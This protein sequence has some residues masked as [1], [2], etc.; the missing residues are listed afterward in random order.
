MSD[1]LPSGSATTQPAAARKSNFWSALS[2]ALVCATAAYIA[3]QIL[4]R[5][6]THAARRMW[7]PTVV[8]PD[9]AETELPAATRRLEFWTPSARTKDHVARE[10]SGIRERD[11]W[12]VLPNDEP[13][14]QFGILLRTNSNVLG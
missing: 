2:I 4:H 1:P 8:R 5:K 10:G 11:K 14:Q 12:E 9:G 13:V 7:T 3:H 6:P